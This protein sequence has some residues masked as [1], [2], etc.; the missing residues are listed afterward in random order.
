MLTIILSVYSVAFSFL[1]Y[2]EF[3]YLVKTDINELHLKGKVKTLQENSY[4]AEEAAGK[5]T[6]GKPFLIST[7]YEL[8][9]QGNIEVQKEYSS[10]DKRLMYHYVFKYD[11]AGRL[12]ERKRAQDTHGNYYS[13]NSEGLLTEYFEGSRRDIRYTMGYEYDA[14]HR[15]VRKAYLDGTGMNT[16]TY[17]GD[18]AT[19]QQYMDNGELSY[20]TSYVYDRSH[21][22]IEKIE[23]NPKGNVFDRKTYAYD[24]AGNVIQELYFLSGDEPYGGEIKTYNANGKLVQTRNLDSTVVL[25]RT[26]NAEGNEASFNKNEKKQIKGNPSFG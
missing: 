8:N 17:S 5:I 21:K 9:E 1:L 19:E 20:A 6:R 26:Y 7:E 13:Y 22:V 4:Y 24:T 2:P 10:Y 14:Q 23:R 12:L 25:I 16:Y 3:Y 11:A 15:L 18:T